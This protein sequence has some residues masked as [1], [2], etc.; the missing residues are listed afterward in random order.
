MRHLKNCG[1]ETAMAESWW[2]RDQLSHSALATC[3]A[4]RIRRCHFSCI[5]SIRPS[6]KG[7]AYRMAKECGLMKLLEINTANGEVTVK[8]VLEYSALFGRTHFVVDVPYTRGER[9]Q[10][11]LVD[12]GDLIRIDVRIECPDKPPYIA[13]ASRS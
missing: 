1:S 11:F 10:H 7:A 9:I 5:I 4:P 8:R 3:D 12:E 6:R 2:V 13:I